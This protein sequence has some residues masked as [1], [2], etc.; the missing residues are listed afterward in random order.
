MSDFLDKITGN[1]PSESDTRNKKIVTA[2][3]AV[4]SI[5]AVLLI[6]LGIIIIAGR[7]TKK[8][9]NG[10]ESDN[11]AV[12]PKTIIKTI[13]EAPSGAVTEASPTNAFAGS[14]SGVKPFPPAST[15]A[16]EELELG[17]VARRK[18][19]CRMAIYHFENAIKGADQISKSE[20]EEAWFFKAVCEADGG[21]LAMAK[22]S[23]LQAQKI[24]L[25]DKSIPGWLKYIDS[26]LSKTK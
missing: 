5:V 15:N 6:V 7:F 12:S 23:F 1:K 19:D 8:G 18:S 22:E 17:R 4:M 26:V 21:K 25:E 13:N 24:N 14:S 3:Y 2:S 16:V 10:D 11:S 9:A 20:L